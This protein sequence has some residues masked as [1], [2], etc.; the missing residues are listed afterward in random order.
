MAAVASARSSRDRGT[1]ILRYRKRG[2][3]YGRVGGRGSF[4]RGTASHGREMS[5]GRQRRTIW[6]MRTAPSVLRISRDG[7]EM[8][9][10]LLTLMFGTGA[11]ITPAP[12]SIAAGESFFR[13]AKAL[14]PVDN[15][16]RVGID[17]GKA[18]EEKK[19]AVASG[20]LKLSDI[21]D[22]RVEVCRSQSECMPMTYTG[23]Y[24]SRDSYEIGFGATGPQLKHSSFVGVKV[25]VDSPLAGVAINWSN[26]SQ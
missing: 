18:T 10:W 20:A 19:R 17:L 25:S 22:I 14:K 3:W 4:E 1:D 23:P 8:L 26:Y 24:F 15:T 21:G 2:V 6:L 5:S 11:A 13:A 16:M 7:E 9:N 12:V